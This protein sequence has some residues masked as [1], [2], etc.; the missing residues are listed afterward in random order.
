MHAVLS[1]AGHNLRLLLNRLR[2]F[3]RW[4]Y[5]LTCSA[6]RFAHE[7]ISI[8]WDFPSVGAVKT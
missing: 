1:G 7:H 2:A 6:P 8:S 5:V 4:L 3:L